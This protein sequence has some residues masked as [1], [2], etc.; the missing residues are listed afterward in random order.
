MIIPQNLL[1][2]VEHERISELLQPIDDFTETQFA[3]CN[4]ER[5]CYMYFSLYHGL[6]RLVIP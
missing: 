6:F 1:C 3:D 5:K 2:Y 4:I